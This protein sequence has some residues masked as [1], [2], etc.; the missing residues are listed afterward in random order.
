MERTMRELVSS[1]MRWSIAFLGFAGVALLWP[2]VVSAGSEGGARPVLVI[3][4][5]GVIA[6]SSA[7]YIISAIKR[8]D[9]E[10]AQALVIEL[11]TPGG[12]DLSMRSIIKEMLSAERPIVVYVSPSGA[13]AASAGAFIT[14]AA[15]VAAMAP[16]ANI[17]AGP[18]AHTG[19]R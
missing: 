14:L 19:G 18:P 16:G 8:A 1:S 5:E 7:D 13:R 9:R 11:D 4:V 15:H 6:P 10:L 17:G 3:R 2:V 12:L